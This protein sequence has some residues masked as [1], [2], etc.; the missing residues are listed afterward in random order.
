[1]P[2]R[3]QQI[4]LGHARFE[5]GP[6][7]GDPDDLTLEVC[8]KDTEKFGCFVTLSTQRLRIVRLLTEG[9]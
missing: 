1:V 6:Q 7:P 8:V 3:S 2:L 4:P 5:L 9:G